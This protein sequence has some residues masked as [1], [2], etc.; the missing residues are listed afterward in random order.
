MFFFFNNFRLISYIASFDSLMATKVFTSYNF[1]FNM[2][3]Q[4]NVCLKVYNLYK[5]VHL[6]EFLLKIYYP[7]EV[8][9]FNTLTN[10]K[11][12]LFD[13]FYFYYYPSLYLDKSIVYHENFVEYFPLKNKFFVNNFYSY[14]YKNSTIYFSVN[15][16]DQFMYAKF[17]DLNQK[18][19]LVHKYFTINDKIYIKDSNLVSK[20]PPFYICSKIY[21]KNYYYYVYKSLILLIYFCNFNENN[22]FF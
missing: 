13:S 7:F 18:Y 17:S 11:N 8:S 14:F 10:E 9:Y 2:I 16:K 6:M 19:F 5:R 4:K 15:S 21:N 22:K 20:V 12:I 3:H 1:F